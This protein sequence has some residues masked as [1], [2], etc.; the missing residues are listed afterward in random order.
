M[1]YCSGEATRKGLV[2]DQRKSFMLDCTGLNIRA[3]LSV[4]MR[5][6][7]QVIELEGKEYLERNQSCLLANGAKRG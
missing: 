7:L 6:K 1:A 5:C 2:A 3:E 4:F